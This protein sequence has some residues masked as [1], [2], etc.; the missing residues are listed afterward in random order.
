MPAMRTAIV[1]SC[2]AAALSAV[3]GAGSPWNAVVEAES[4]HLHPLSAAAG[5]SSATIVAT[6]LDAML[7]SFAL[8][9]STPELSVDVTSCVSTSVIISEQTVRDG[10][11]KQG[12]KLTANVKSTS[13]D[14][15]TGIG[16]FQLASCEAHDVAGY[17]PLVPEGSG[18]ETLLDVADCQY[19]AI[20]QLNTGTSTTVSGLVGV[21]GTGACISP[22]PA[23]VTQAILDSASDSLSILRRSTTNLCPMSGGAIAG[24]VIACLAGVGVAVYGALAYSGVAPAPR[25]GPAKGETYGL[26]PAT[27]A[28][29]TPGTGG[30]AAGGTSAYATAGYQTA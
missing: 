28:V 30:P 5:D 10:A 21:A 18:C 25:C 3:V 19:F 26:I 6:S 23:A 9:V 16:G 27:G 8:S 12:I 11:T 20:V 22:V 14:K 17:A 4:G 29:P 15:S 7:G 13:Y 1:S 24:I 2:L